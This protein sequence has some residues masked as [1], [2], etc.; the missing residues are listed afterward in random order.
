[1]IGAVAGDIIGSI[2]EWSLTKNYNFELFNRKSCFTDDTVLTI[3]TAEALLE[4]GTEANRKDF[5]RAYMKW[6]RKYPHA[7][8]GGRFREWLRYGDP[9]IVIDSFGNGS[10]MRVSPVAWVSDDIDIVL[11]LAQESAAITHS[12]PEGIKGAQAVAA[13]IY[14]ARYG[15]N[16][17]SI[18]LNLE[19]MFGYDL[20]RKIIDIKATY[21]FN[22][23]CQ[24]SVPEAIIAFLEA[25]SYE[26]AVRL[27]VSLGGDT[28]TQACM[29]GS[30]AEAV[31]PVPQE[32]KE[33]SQR[34]L[35]QELYQI[36]NEFEKKH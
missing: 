20:S 24:G 34:I 15:E 6:G 5:S 8:Y 18:R 9:S 2:Y 23:T 3:A 28:D 30:M 32:I 26:D 31:W 29:A 12:H 21:T 10:A 17:E 36:I 7:G 33:R 4:K 27:A 11:K 14:M 35:T 1:M 19:R 22:V 16:K 25:N 13:A